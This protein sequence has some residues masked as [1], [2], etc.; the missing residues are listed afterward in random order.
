MS[1]T[2][3]IILFVLCIVMLLT[4]LYCAVV[5][6]RLSI[7]FSIYALFFLI[8]S[9][10]IVWKIWGG[11]ASGNS[12]KVPTTPTYVAKG[13]LAFY[14]QD[15][16]DTSETYYVETTKHDTYKFCYFHNDGVHIVKKEVPADKVNLVCQ[17]N[18]LPYRVE[19]YLSAR[20]GEPLYYELHLPDD[21]N[22]IQLDTDGK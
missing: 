11:V 7:V 12:A 15:G 4:S 16:A 14:V 19:I 1:F 18:D 9:L 22:A 21:A 8:A 17:E 20:D 5:V 10:V 3:M 2:L 13:H 6:R